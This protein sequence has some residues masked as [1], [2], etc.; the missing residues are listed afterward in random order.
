MGVLTNIIAVCWYVCVG[1]ITR[2]RPTPKRWGGEVVFKRIATLI[3]QFNTST[4]IFT[5]RERHVLINEFSL[6]VA[7]LD[8]VKDRPKPAMRNGSAVAYLLGYL[9]RLVTMDRFNRITAQCV[10]GGTG[11]T[12]FRLLR[13]GNDDG[14]RFWVDPSEPQQQAKVECATQPE[15]ETEYCRGDGVVVSECKRAGGTEASANN[16]A[17]KAEHQWRADSPAHGEFHINKIPKM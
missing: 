9:D 12:V 6:Q 11:W 7:N 13:L 16:R 17:D 14:L 3:S 2:F 4:M 10:T 1:R 8:T 5:T 15:G